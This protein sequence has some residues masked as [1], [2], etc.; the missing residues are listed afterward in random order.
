MND[1]SAGLPSAEIE[2][3]GDDDHD[4]SG[5]DKKHP[6]PPGIVALDPAHPPLPSS[7]QVGRAGFLTSVESRRRSTAR[8]PANP[9][10]AR[11]A[12]SPTS[13]SKNAQLTWNSPLV[14]VADAPARTTKGVRIHQ[15]CSQPKPDAN[16]T[17]STRP[18][19][20]GSIS[21]MNAPR[22]PES[23]RETAS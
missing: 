6:A 9:I 22:P 18:A 13:T 16:S 11:S 15:G 8:A 3:Q 1:A 7:G 20:I 21:S 19:A 5:G 10:H 12:T 17:P 2:E 4:E 23:A 14:T